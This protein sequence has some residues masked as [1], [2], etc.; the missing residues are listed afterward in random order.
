MNK[1]WVPVVLLSSLLG[2]CAELNQM[3]EE[4]NRREAQRNQQTRAEINQLLDQRCIGYGFRPGTDAFATCK[5]TELNNAMKTLERQQA[6]R[7]LTTC[8]NEWGR[9]VP[10]SSLPPK[11]RT[12]DTNCTHVGGGNY[13]CTSTSNSW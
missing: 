3:L 12:T 4:S 10:C 13:N 5:Q 7:Q 9:E 11:Q 6:V 2:G 1:L 8:K